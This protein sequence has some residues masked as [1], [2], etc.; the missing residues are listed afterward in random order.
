MTAA[1]PPAV[2]GIDLGTSSVKVVLTGP[3]G[4]VRAQA[5]ADYPVTRPHPGWSETD[6]AAWWSAIRSA[7]AQVLAAEPGAAPVGIGLSG[8]MHG[9]VLADADGRPTR[10]A[11]LW[12]DARAGAETAL[13]R[14]LGPDTRPRLGNPV[15][16][17]MAGPQLAWLHRHE[18]AVVAASRWALQPKDW[19]RARLTGVVAAEP[20]DASATLLFDVLTGDWSD[21]VVAA[22]GVR[23]ELLPD[24]LPSAGAAAGA[25]TGDTA[26]ELGLPAGI[27]V[28]AGAADTA[29]AAL[30]SGLFV[31]GSVQ[32]TVGTGV[33]VVSPAPTPTAASLSADP[34]AHL[35]RS[36]TADGWYAMGASMTGG[37][38]LDWVR[39]MLGAEW[40]ELYA[41]AGHRPEPGDPVFLPHLVGERTPYLDTGL[42]GA[43]TGLAAR[44]DR[45]L[46]LYAALEGVAFA[47]ADALEALPGVPDDGRV[48]RIAGG[49]SVHPAWRRLLADVLRADLH[50][51]DVP[52]ASARGAALLGARAAGL[53]DDR[54]L[55]TV[56]QVPA[57]PVA[58]PGDRVPA[59]AARRRRYLDTL[60][61]LRPLTPE[62]GADGDG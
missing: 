44:H 42:R 48:L 50:A 38:T 34:V 60:A 39:R 36:A 6:P 32:L 13:Y 53:L 31:P 58:A 7:V 1:P 47:A 35:Y 15:V 2:L 62:D 37:Q 29:A 28:A 30:G 10:P 55:E 11:V 54:T 57:T 61:A 3:D 18:P 27:P 5:G 26:T 21:D 49:G 45:D 23:R 19:V 16:P 4:A 40:V 51:V 17:G 52:G 25:L 12:A 20:S 59:L 41:A 46:M 24:L 33:Q 43:W 9:V 56:A 22:L 14:E 8:Q